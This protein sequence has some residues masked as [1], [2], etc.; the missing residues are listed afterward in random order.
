MNNHTTTLTFSANT[1]KFCTL[2]KPLLGRGLGRPGF[3]SMRSDFT[4]FANAAFIAC[5]PTVIKVMSMA[6][7]PANAN[8]TPAAQRGM[9]MG[10]DNGSIVAKATADGLASFSDY[11]QLDRTRMGALIAPFF[12]VSHA[13][14]KLLH[15][16]CISKKSRPN[17]SNGSP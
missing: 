16:N 15:S 14:T 12:L 9:P 7:I 5:A 11:S 8:T 17:A 2:L 13:Q 10:Y 6:T 1:F 4:G 3:Y